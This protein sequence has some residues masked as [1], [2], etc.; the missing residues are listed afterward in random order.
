M[1]RRIKS[2]LARLDRFGAAVDNAGDGD[3][4][5]RRVILFER[6]SSVLHERTSVLTSS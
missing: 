6:V 3:E 2:I 1:T 5:N 4:L